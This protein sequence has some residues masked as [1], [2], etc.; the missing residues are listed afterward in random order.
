MP[1][2]TSTTTTTVV[3]V[4]VIGS[5]QQ[6]YIYLFLATVQ[7]AIHQH[8]HQLPLNTNFASRLEYYILSR[9]DRKK[10]KLNPVY[11]LNCSQNNNQHQCTIIIL[12]L[13]TSRNC[14]YSCI[15]PIKRITCKIRF[16]DAPDQRKAL[17]N[18]ETM[19]LQD[20]AQV[21]VDFSHFFLFLIKQKYIARTRTFN[22]I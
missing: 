11:R 22:I 14:R 5:S 9:R 15:S 2:A 16:R 6:W 12:I 13:D 10:L 20:D 17:I 18:V 3:V 8:Q 19:K 21:K 7:Y 4:I 1:Q